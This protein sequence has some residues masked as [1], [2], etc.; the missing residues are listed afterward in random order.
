MPQACEDKR[1]RMI[2][3]LGRG[4]T[5]DVARVQVGDLGREAALKYPLPEILSITADFAA[6]TRREYDLI[7]GLRFPGL[8]R[9]IEP[10]HTDP[11]Y[12]L[13]EL[14][15][16][17]TLDTVGRV[18]DVPTALRLLSAVALSLEYL[19]VRNLVHGDLKPHNVFLPRDW[20]RIPVTRLFYA[21]LSDFSLGRKTDEPES[22]RA[23]LGTVGYMAPEVIGQITTSHQSDLFA[24]GVIAY[25]VLTGVHP[26]LLDDAE[27]VRVNGRI[28]ELSVPSVATLRPELAGHPVTALVEQLLA[29]LST[30]RP[31]TAYDVCVALEGAGSK[32]PFRRG[33]R[34]SHLM[35]SEDSF[36]TVSERMLELSSTDRRQLSTFTGEDIRHLTLL[37]SGNFSQG[38]LEYR[39]GQY[40]FISGVRWPAH[41]RR[42]VWNRFKGSSLAVK[43]QLI[44]QSISHE[45]GK[46]KAE[47]RPLLAILR[48]FLSTPT[49][50]RISLREAPKA[51]RLEEQSRGAL[52]WLQAG[53]LEGAERCAYQAATLL[54][55]ESRWQES[56]ETVERVIDFARLQAR[57]PEVA[58]LMLL[59]GTVYKDSGD[60][61]RA[62][63]T[64][65]E[66]IEVLETRPAQKTLGIVY[67]KLGDLYK[68]RSDFEA[69]LAALQKALPIFE[70]L[71]DRLEYSHTCNNL[72]NIY[73]LIGDLNRSS[74]QFRRAL[75]LQRKLDS[76]TDIAST[77][78][79]LGTNLCLAGK[80]KRGSFL[81][82][83]SLTI[84]REL[85]NAGEI[86]RTLNNLGY[87][88]Y[89]T[90]D[91]DRAIDFLS[92]SLELN[93]RVGSRKEIMINL[94]NLSSIMTSSG[95][96][97]QARTL[98]REGLEMSR[99][100]EDRSLELLFSA[101]M[102]NA[103]IR[104]GRLGEASGLLV[105]TERFLTEVDDPVG[106]VLHCLASAHYLVAVGNLSSAAQLA[107]RALATAQKCSDAHGELQ[108]VLLLTRL[109]AC[110]ELAERTEHLLA[111]LH[112]DR[113]RPVLKY[114][115]SER[116]LRDG[117][118]SGATMLIEGHAAV[119]LSSTV[120]AD[121]P[122]L[123]LIAAE[124]SLFGGK[125][126]PARE[127]LGRARRLAS[128]FGLA[129]ELIS[130]M[131]M[132]GRLALEDGDFE[133]AFS[134]FK[135]ALQLAKQ[136]SQSISEASDRATFQNK[137]EI[138]FLVAE[139]KRLGLVLGQKKS[140]RF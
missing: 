94:E 37:M 56:L 31:A 27:P 5:A 51:E 84:K 83:T 10:P 136:M 86:A 127:Y 44:V 13:L 23:G 122:R 60:T 78:S 121:I 132:S 120:D 28:Q 48:Q 113:M 65:K 30:D 61:I 112:F 133:T 12:L 100:L 99:A 101:G 24:F 19:R 63:A 103:L 80:M 9:L 117:D 139:V 67:N 102:A 43:R 42:R 59:K 119:P 82:H 75:R 41:L 29:K 46:V 128:E 90:G 89:V 64:Y 130:A 88:S 55:K 25:Q 11:D 38:N 137:R 3:S 116:L 21:K 40:R 129:A 34:P 134:E 16:G 77:L 96:V 4:G 92:E 50:R 91:N 74:Q 2:A 72:G 98:L 58:E 110:P 125:K 140:G 85:G 124:C 76:R 107:R 81:L 45:T 7:G 87:F 35:H 1:F 66:L 104:L 52:L 53:N 71:G 62:E 26:F 32:Y 93:R 73:W 47:D 108:A 70:Q 131:V 33:I 105:S 17:P 115:E 126:G 54:M 14:C 95:Q 97:Q 135:S 111:D 22:S 68:M 79:N 106:T 18:E 49:V 118:T 69:G 36:S 138:Q 15:Q 20:E 57:M 123:C 6:L 8:V 114:N 109:T 39:R